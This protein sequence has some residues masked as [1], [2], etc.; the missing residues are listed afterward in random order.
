MNQ[1][2]Y[3]IKAGNSKKS[4]KPIGSICSLPNHLTSLKPLYP[5]MHLSSLQCQ[6]YSST[7][8]QLQKRQ[9]QMLQD[10]LLLQ[11]SQRVLKDIIRCV[12]FL[13]T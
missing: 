11:G 7:Q 5:T 12:Y 1:K 2:S 10:F 4:T 3:M 9:T 13:D 6:K 8:T